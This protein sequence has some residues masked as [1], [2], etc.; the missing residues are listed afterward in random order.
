MTD[1]FLRH[2][3]CDSCGIDDTPLLQAATKVFLDDM[4]AASIY[5][6]E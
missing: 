3:H 4:L 2:P 6:A 1:F 5:C